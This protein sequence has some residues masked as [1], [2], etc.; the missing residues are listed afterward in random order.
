MKRGFK[1]HELVTLAVFFAGGDARQVDTEDVAVKVNEL[2]PGRFTW[3]KYRDQINIEIVRAFLSDAKKKKYGSLLLGTGTTGWQ[4]TDVG[5][6]F[7]QANSYRAATPAQQAQRLSKDERRRRSHELGRVA[8]SD[9]FQKYAAGQRRQIT[10][11]EIE[12]V[13]RLDD[14]VV[15]E[16]RIKKVQRLL[17]VL[18]DDDEVGDAVRFFA[19]LATREQ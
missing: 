13:F 18:G 15:G 1:N 10:R 19:L 12:S 8:A 11:R 16:A 17:N 7:A 3:R 14:Y 4:L 2:A 6:R 9:A 5:L